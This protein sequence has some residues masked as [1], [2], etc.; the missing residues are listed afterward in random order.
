MR[1]QFAYPAFWGA[2][3]E[4]ASPGYGTVLLSHTHDADPENDESDYSW[5]GHA[6]YSRCMNYRYALLRVWDTSR[7]IYGAI[8]LNPSTATEYVLDPTVTRVLT[9]V[10]SELHEGDGL[11]AYGGMLVMN[12]FAFRA[13]DPKD[14]RAAKDPIGR[15]NNNVIKALAYRCKQVLC[16]W[17]SHGSFRERGKHAE[18]LLRS[19]HIKPLIIAM[20]KCGNPVHPLYQ[21]Y[22]KKPKEWKRG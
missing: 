22:E 18:E 17:G 7:P 3:H 16:G 21:S 12:I 5:V 19:M 10:R 9:R 14:M 6:L 1:D 15:E 8:M 2:L 4:L 11:C 13:T 20:T